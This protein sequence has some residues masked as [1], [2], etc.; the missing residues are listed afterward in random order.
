MQRFTKIL[1]A[2]IVVIEQQS[3]PCSFKTS[4]GNIRTVNVRFQVSELLNDMKMIAFL[5]GEISN[6]AKYFSSFAN[7]SSD[8][9]NNLKGTFGNDENSTWQPW[10]YDSRKKIAKCVE[11]FK[12]TVQK[13]KLAESTKR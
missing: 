1:V 6:A 5:C 13:Q 7:V 12:K 8:N 9:V 11:T 4:S 2:D 10:N 3:F